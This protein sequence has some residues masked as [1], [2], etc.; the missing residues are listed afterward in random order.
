MRPPTRGTAFGMFN[1]ASGVALLVASALAGLLWDQ[2]GR[3]RHL[4]GRR[5]AFS[6]LALVGVP[7][8]AHRSHPTKAPAHTGLSG[9]V[10][11]AP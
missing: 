6:T 3:Q 5:G 1:L 10:G 8:R 7:A 2:W 4:S 11:P 9:A